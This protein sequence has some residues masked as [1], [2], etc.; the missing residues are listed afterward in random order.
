MNRSSRRVFALLSLAILAGC[1]R[2]AVDAAADRVLRYDRPAQSW[3]EA[4]PVG[5]GRLGAMVFG[6]VPRERIQF[7]EETLWTG[8]PHDYSHP[9]AS[10][11]LGK[12]R[13][14]LFAGKPREAEALAMERF[15]SVPLGQMAY[16][17]F[18]DLTIDLPGHERFTDYGRSLDIGRALSGVTY[19]VNGTAFTR[20]VFAS[21]P[22]QVIV[23]RLTADRRKALAFNV[24]L[25]SP[26]ETKSLSREGDLQTLTVAVK[27][28]ALRGVAL[29][30]VETDGRIDP[31]GRALAVTDA[32]R[33][34][35]YLAAATNFVNYRDVSGDAARRAGKISTA[36]KR[37]PSGGSGTTHVADHRALFD[38][39]DIDLGSNGRESLPM[40]RRLRD[41]AAAPEDPGLVALYVPVRPLPDDR[42]A[43]VP[44]TQP[45]NL[46]GI[47]NQDLDPAWGSKYTTN[48]NAE[49]NYWPAEVTNLGDC[50]EP[51]FRLIEECAETGRTHSPGPLRRRGLGAPPQHRHLA[52][53]RAHQ[54][55]QSRP[56]A[57]RAAAGSA[58]TCGSISCSAA[59]WPFS[60]S[61]P[62][63]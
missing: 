44:A 33:A 61:G 4:L 37:S 53:H 19:K 1:G 17:P 31:A 7:N 13:E 26:H 12:I 2:P 48:I 3:N 50:Q 47:W 16:Q 27:D 23:V 25:D 29:L 57:R 59:T 34:T 30:R 41:F 58:G 62:S 22:D 21:H 43:A 38:R 39:F 40:D 15:M 52:G 10:E 60:G 11:Y 24:S 42:L 63:R 46:Q 55:F 20:E 51:F 14:L 5:N 18:G 35:I 6:G 49:M 56:V 28:G 36:S 32:R 8:G 9:G 54:P 45:A